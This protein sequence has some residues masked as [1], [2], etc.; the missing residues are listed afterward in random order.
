L[1]LLLEPPAAGAMSS[2]G[3]TGGS[4]VGFLIAAAG[5]SGEGL[6]AGWPPLPPVL[7]LAAR[8]CTLCHME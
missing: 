1:L 4:D 3:D 7:L 8:C 5:L 6:P 2:S